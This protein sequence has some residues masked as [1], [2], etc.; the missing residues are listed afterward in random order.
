MCDQEAKLSNLCN[1]FFF[2][3]TWSKTIRTRSQ[4]SITVLFFL[5]E[6]CPRKHAD[7]PLFLLIISVLLSNGALWL[8]WDEAIYFPNTMNKK[9][10]KIT[11]TWVS[12]LNLRGRVFLDVFK[13]IIQMNPA[14]PHSTC[15]H[16]HLSD[17]KIR[18]T[19]ISKTKKTHIFTQAKRHTTPTLNCQSV[20]WDVSVVWYI[21][22]G[23]VLP[24]RPFTLEGS[25]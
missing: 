11:L 2:C 13:E 22:A 6:F 23:L 9:N 14:S 25:N 15:E 19:Y 7:G 3:V 20:L 12:V 10:K 16:L 21:S 17:A 24:S 5:A 18:V 1:D 8:W 4:F